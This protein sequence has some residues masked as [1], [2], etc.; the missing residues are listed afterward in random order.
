MAVTVY[1]DKCKGLSS[2]PVDGICIKVCAMDAIEI[3]DDFPT[4]NENACTPCG[5]CVV[6]CPLEALSK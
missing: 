5:L 1:S 3:K 2:C 4:I 6:N